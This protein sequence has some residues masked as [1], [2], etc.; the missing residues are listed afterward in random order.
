MELDPY[1]L[2]AAMK[3]LDTWFAEAKTVDYNRVFPQR[4][5][6]LIYI[7]QAIN[8]DGYIMWRALYEAEQVALAQE[9]TRQ[10]KA[11][12]QQPDGTYLY[13]SMAN[14]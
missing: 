4:P 11:K 8:F 10:V 14:R 5:R 3:L 6:E 1:M 13:D 2:I 9:L 12:M 7:A